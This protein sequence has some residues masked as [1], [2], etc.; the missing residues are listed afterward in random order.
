M[1]GV[2]PR[3]GARTSQAERRGV[4][5]VASVIPCVLLGLALLS[6]CARAAAPALPIAGE[7]APDAELVRTAVAAARAGDGVR[8]LWPGFWN[9][10]PGFLLY[11]SAYAVVVLARDPGAGFAP[12]G[13]AALPGGSRAY[14][15][16]G[17]L[18]RLG[19][20][21]DLAYPLG[22]DTVVA[23]PAGR[24]GGPETLETLFHES[25]HAFQR[26][27]FI[28]PGAE[29]PADV[30]AL[31]SEF[32]ALAEVERLILLRALDARPGELGPVLAEYAAVRARR[33]ALASPT[34]NASEN[35]I[36]RI[37]GSAQ[38]VGLRA[39]QSARGRDARE[40]M[41]EGLRVALEGTP[42]TRLR[43]RVYGTGA[44][45]GHLLGTM[46]VDWK[47]RLQAGAT[48]AELLTQAL[49]GTPAPDARSVDSAL[50]RYGIQAIRR[51][52]AAAASAPQPA[53]APRTGGF[54][55]VIR[56]SS[57]DGSTEL[58]DF[59]VN[60]GDGEVT[61]PEPGLTTFTRPE[62]FAF[63]Y[64]G[65]DVEVRGRATTLDLRA[66]PGRIDVVVP[67][68]RAPSVDGAAPPPGSRCMPRALIAG[69]GL[70][71]AGGP[72]CIHV[73]PDS[74]IAE[75]GPARD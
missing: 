55:L 71:L 54:R 4:R 37:E 9:P 43:R 31:A 75:P 11:D 35:Q 40:G 68:P 44:A 23:I 30:P 24:A 50:E 58:P 17:P 66:A 6:A 29:L 47:P 34:A 19:G 7:A 14:A 45:L 52:L 2:I 32:S 65:V 26:G 69:E 3:S 12:V 38:W 62:V 74:A 5:G 18:P 67:L 33:A 39:A 60:M 72:V 63:R 64:G 70:R 46:G 48:F 15:A 51:E 36:E 22:G 25:F 28:R 53:A 13:P 56:L 1:R 61:A 42:A 57:P 20:T 21:L 10:A 73:T 59:Q 27:H 16:P 49:I 41:R 8:T